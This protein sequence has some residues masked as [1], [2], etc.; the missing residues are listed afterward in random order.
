MRL[1]SGFLAEKEGFARCAA[2]RAMVAPL[3]SRSHGSLACWASASLALPLAALASAPLASK[4]AL[5]F[6]SIFNNKKALP[7][8]RFSV[9]GEG[10]I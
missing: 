6:K 8:E 4:L 1:H 2:Q 7:L 10:G 5:G 3:R 9:G